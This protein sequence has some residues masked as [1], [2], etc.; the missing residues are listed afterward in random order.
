MKWIFLFCALF[1]ATLHASDVDVRMCGVKVSWLE[2]FFTHAND[3]RAKCIEQAYEA[4]KRKLE[5]ELDQLH[6]TQQQLAQ[7][8]KKYA[9]KVDYNIV[10]CDPP[11]GQAANPQRTAKCRDLIRAEN[12]IIDRID[13]IMGWKS[14]PLPEN[15]AQVSNAEV[16]PPCPSKERLQQIQAIRYFNPTLYQTW[17][18][19]VMLQPENYY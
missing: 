10:R 19:C 5:A 7:E 2:N 8:L 9:Y 17:E 14:K 11:Q 3:I 4:N 18:R 15:R 13:E 6:K 16:T 1:S 12:A